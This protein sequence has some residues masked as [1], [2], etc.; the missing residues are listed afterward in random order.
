[1]VK[2]AVQLILKRQNCEMVSRVL[3]QNWSIFGKHDPN[4]HFTVLVPQY[5]NEF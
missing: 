5:Q 2:I 4:R 3:K 1:M